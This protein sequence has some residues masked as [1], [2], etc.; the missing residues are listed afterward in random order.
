M[1][2]SDTMAMALARML[3]ALGWAA[4]CRYSQTHARWE[5]VVEGRYA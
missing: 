4:V 3:S 5:V 1:R 2:L